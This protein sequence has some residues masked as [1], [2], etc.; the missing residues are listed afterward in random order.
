M[1]IQLSRIN[2]AN[3][4]GD[5]GDN[6]DFGIPA[7]FDFYVIEIA[8]NTSPHQNALEEATEEIRDIP[9]SVSHVRF[10]D[11]ALSHLCDL[12]EYDEYPEY[13]PVLLVTD[14]V[15]RE[16]TDGTN[17]IEIRLGRYSPDQV[18][19]ILND[20]YRNLNSDEFGRIR[21]EE[22]TRRLREGLPSISGAASVV[23][24]M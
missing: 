24:L 19:Q 1:V 22:R 16:Y 12:Y 21:W 5:D 14:T 15:P 17:I 6:P 7:Q 3:D 18:P 9:D 8:R 23:A 4:L 11:P 10:E 2:Q 13:S 20:I